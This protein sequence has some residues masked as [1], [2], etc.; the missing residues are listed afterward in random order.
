MIKNVFFS[1]KEKKNDS[2]DILALIPCT[3]IE[4]ERK[5]VNWHDIKT[6]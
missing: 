4:T 6:D 1:S 3:S 2:I 5:F